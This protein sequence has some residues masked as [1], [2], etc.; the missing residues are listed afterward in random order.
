MSEPRHFRRFLIIWIVVSVVLT[1]LAVLL[2]APKLPPGK[3]TDEGSGEVSD[4]AVLIG[5]STPVFALILVYF[6]YALIA[7]R[8]R[9]GA[10]QEGPAIRGDSRVQT[11]WLVVT[12][13][14]VVFAA[15]FG[16][17]RLAQAGAGG[18]QGPTPVWKPSSANPLQVQVIGQQWDWTYRFPT[19]GGVETPRLELPV[20][21]EIELH[22]TSLDVIHSFWARQL[23]VKADANP[24]V[25]NVAYVHP[26][27]T[28]TFDIRCAEL[29]GLFH[30]HMFQTGR[31]VTGGQ[32]HA[33][34]K[35][36]QRVFAPATKKLN[37]YNPSY[38]PKPLRRAG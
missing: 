11:A 1:L 12:S 6:A 25:D 2:A 30:G 21:R 19:F 33:W 5:I 34:I 16:S 26:S 31:I 13:V 35:R 20:H 17:I 37:P 8:Q 27:D 7:F 14:I 38:L 18:G 4:N 28:G 24:G 3:L 9:A 23:A 36:E 10:P 22:V 32:F 15:V 29:C